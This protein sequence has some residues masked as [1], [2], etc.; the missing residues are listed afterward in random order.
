MENIELKLECRDPGLAR[1]I[2]LTYG[3]RFAGTQEQTDTYFRLSRGRLKKRES[4][5]EA[6]E[7]IYYERPDQARA[8]TST[9]TLYTEVEARRQFG[10]RKLPVWVVVRKRRDVFLVGNVRIYLDAVEGLGAFVEFEAMVSQGQS[11]ARCHEAIAD[12][13]EVL[14]PALGEPVALSYSDL[15]AQGAETHGGPG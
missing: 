11:A 3:A 5:G 13:R 10:R 1:S 2:C 4:P 6:P 15:A 12:L 9:F 14:A 8:R 7:W